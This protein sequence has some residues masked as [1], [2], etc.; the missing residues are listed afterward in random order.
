MPTAKDVDCDSVGVDL[1]GDAQ[2]FVESRD[3]TVRELAGVAESQGDE[4]LAD[5]S[6]PGHL[7]GPVPELGGSLAS[8]A[9]L[10]EQ[11][12]GVDDHEI[13]GRPCGRVV[14]L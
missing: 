10:A 13:A 2:G 9:S 1:L 12:M 7:A 11:E 14:A 8:L 4:G 6:R 3:G 5:R